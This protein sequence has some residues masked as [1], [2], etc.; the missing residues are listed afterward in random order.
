MPIN[1]IA[2]KLITNVVIS[3]IVMRSPIT[4]NAVTPATNGVMLPI[5]NY[6]VILDKAA[7]TVKAIKPI[8]ARNALT[9]TGFL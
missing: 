2:A 6:K 8:K 1:I 9:K 5:V 3:K 7:P 4:K